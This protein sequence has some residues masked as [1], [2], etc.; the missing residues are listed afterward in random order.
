MARTIH[1]L[2]PIALTRKMAPGYHADGGGLYLQVIDAGSKSW[3]FRY[4]MAGKRREMRLGPFSAVTTKGAEKRVVS[5]QHAR[6][7]ATEARALVKGGKR[8]PS[9]SGAS[10][11]P[12]NGS[13]RPGP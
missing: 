11:R 13:P 5:L 10:S 3:V 12:W 9:L 1:R 2:E 4:S 7:K 6:G 8:S